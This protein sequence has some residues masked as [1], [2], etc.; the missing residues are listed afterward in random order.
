MPGLKLNKALPI[1]ALAAG[2]R[3]CPSDPTDTA[4]WID[5]SGLP[6]T[7]ASAEMTYV[8]YAGTEVCAVTFEPSVDSM[9]FATLVDEDCP[10]AGNVG[11][12]VTEW[13]MFYPVEDRDP[14]VQIGLDWVD[15]DGTAGGFDLMD[16]EPKW[17]HDFEA[18]GCRPHIKG[19][20]FLDPE[21]GIARLP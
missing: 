2:C 16:E 5:I 14:I 1:L 18:I 4:L 7:I 17:H 11:V 3:T 15:A 21:G 20:L 8:S 9:Q 19:D 6:A 12:Y 10:G 13:W